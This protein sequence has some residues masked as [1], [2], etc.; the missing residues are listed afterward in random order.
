MVYKILVL[1]LLSIAIARYLIFLKVQQS[2]SQPSCDTSSESG[3]MIARIDNANPREGN[4]NTRS[5]NVILS[6]AIGYGHAEFEMF[7]IPL[8]YHHTGD[9]IILV[10]LELNN[11]L[12]LFCQR[13]LVKLV[14]NVHLGYIELERFAWYADMCSLYTG[15]CLA[16]DFRDT[17]FQ[18]N[19]FQSNIHMDFELIL[20]AES[21][22]WTI[23]IGE[24]NNRSIVE[25]FGHNI[26]K[27]IGNSTV[28]NGG[29]VLGK[30]EGFNNFSR[31]I[32]QY[33]TNSLG[34][35]CNDQGVIN[36]LWYTHKLRAFNVTVQ[37]R[38]YGIVNVMGC[39][40][41]EKLR[42]ELDRQGCLH[43]KDGSL[44]PVV[45]QY[46]RFDILFHN[47]KNLTECIAPQH[48]KCGQCCPKNA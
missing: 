4:I 10:H 15:H 44:S 39:L 16:V 5:G 35:S 32:S 48:S 22:F 6:V 29:A 28:I 20:F 1:I 37:R 7:L 47:Y 13:Y 25:C 43:N 40:P 24:R 41:W 30:A 11:T 27:E 42:N 19:P 21:E 33:S 3:D 2:T 38:G 18:R 45:H 17:Y 31:L 9:I 36:Y 26:Q 46:D 12:R 14:S 8:R 23:A 34:G